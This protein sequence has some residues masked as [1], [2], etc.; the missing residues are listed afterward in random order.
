MTSSGLASMFDP[1]SAAVRSMLSAPGVQVAAAAELVAAG[2]PQ[3]QSLDVARRVLA[4]A[5]AAFP[6]KEDRQANAA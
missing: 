5:L 4:A 6:S 1:K 3:D 2:V